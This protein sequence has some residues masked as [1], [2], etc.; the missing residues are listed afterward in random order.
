MAGMSLAGAGSV[1]T[2]FLRHGAGPAEE[3]GLQQEQQD[4]H[5]GRGQARGRAHDRLTDP[6]QQ[7]GELV[8]LASLHLLPNH[9]G[10]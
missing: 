7:L 4:G 10:I 8:R 3:V 9:L 2:S 5:G 1:L 6:Q